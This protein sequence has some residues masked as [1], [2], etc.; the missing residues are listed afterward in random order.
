MAN[1]RTIAKLEARIHERVAYCLDFEIS[2]PRAGMITVT[3]VKLST[4]LSIADV[5]YTVLGGTADRNKAEHML[6]SARGFIQR[7]LGRVLSMRRTPTLRFHYDE[8]LEEAQ[9]IDRLIAGALERDRQIHSSGT[10]PVGEDP[11][12]DTPRD[13]EEPEDELEPEDE[14][15]ADEAD[16]SLSDESEEGGRAP[17]PKPS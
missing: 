10:A 14:E 2:D 16:A 1:P 4:D 6:Q 11:D 8:S 3:G 9:R 17:S 7:Q 13:A 5:R 12:L 15:F